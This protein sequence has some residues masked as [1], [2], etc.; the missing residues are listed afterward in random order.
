MLINDHPGSKK[1]PL[2]VFYGSI[3]DILSYP[4]EI[5]DQTLVAAA[6]ICLMDHGQFIWN[7]HLEKF[8]N[9]AHF[10]K[11]LHEKYFAII[12]QAENFFAGFKPDQCMLIISAGFDA[13]VKETS[14]MQRHGRNVPD[15]F[16][17]EFTEEAMK[18][19]RKCWYATIVFFFFFC[20]VFRL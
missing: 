20:K 10:Q 16:Y 19:A 4:T 12:R 15:S 3:H 14:W 1:K 18:V 7:V 13:H 11:L 9:K 8:T 2:K 5:Y 6:S 17:H